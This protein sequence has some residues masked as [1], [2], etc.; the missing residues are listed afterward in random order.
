MLGRTGKLEG[1]ASPKEDGARA[2][3]D[4]STH[5]DWRPSA[6][7]A[8][9]FLGDEALEG[10]GSRTNQDDIEAANQ[11]IQTANK[12]G[13]VVHTFFTATGTNQSNNN[14]L[15]D[16]YA[17]VAKETGGTAFTDEDSLEGFTAVLKKIICETRQVAIDRAPS[18]TSVDSQNPKP[19]SV[20]S[21][22]LEVIGKA[23]VAG[24]NSSAIKSES[25]PYPTSIAS[26]VSVDLV[27]IAD[28]GGS[29]KNEAQALSKAADN[30]IQSV[31]KQHPDAD[32]KITWLGVG[33]T[34]KGT[35]VAETF[36]DYLS[37]TVNVMESAFLGKKLWAKKKEQYSSFVA[38]RA[39][40]GL[41]HGAVL[42]YPDMPYLKWTFQYQGV[43]KKGLEIF[44]NTP[45]KDKSAPVDHDNPKTF[46]QGCEALH[47]MFQRFGKAAPQHMENSGRPFAEIKNTVDEIFNFQGGQKDRAEKWQQAAKAGHL[48]TSAESIPQYDE[49][50]W[51]QERDNLEE[52]ESSSEAVKKPIYRFFQAAAHHRTYVL[53]DLLPAHG[54]IVN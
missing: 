29:M 19:G 49:N 7:C 38:E 4:I 1:Y 10:G 45:E 40:G 53:R 16:E 35:K 39:S 11:A 15:R 54:L 37:K 32:I 31:K 33:G 26:Q 50:D 34:W 2:M 36:R 13:M 12:K 52:L 14:S 21:P 48:F 25:K 47:G 6:T 43:K 51:H 17:R 22:E 18:Q 24:K 42:T 8:M 27:V 30:A 20:E 46:L 9:L 41:G 44:R 23:P 5:F 3:E 28:T